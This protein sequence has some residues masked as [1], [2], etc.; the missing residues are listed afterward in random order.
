MAVRS[1]LLTTLA[2]LTLGCGVEPAGGEG[3]LFD[4]GPIPGKGDE[5][6]SSTS[7]HVTTWVPH[8]GISAAKRRLQANYGS[9]PPRE[10]ITRLALQ[11]YLPTRTGG[12]KLAGAASATDVAWFRRYCDDND[13]ELYLCIYN[14]NTKW[15]WPL[16]RSA[17]KDHRAALIGDL[18]AEAERRNFDGVDIDFEGEDYSA[19]PYAADRP[20]FARFIKE[21]A[22]ELHARGKKLTIDSTSSIYGVPNHNWWPDWA[23][24]ADAINVMGYDYTYKNGAGIANYAYQQ[25]RGLNDGFQAHQVVM[26]MPGWLSRWGG[27]SALD[28]ITDCLSGL[29]EPSG[30]AIWDAQLPAEAWRSAAVWDA[31]HEIKT[32]GR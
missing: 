28:N 1:L 4:E 32:V 9:H 13:I 26:G 5:P 16:A 14:S 25:R 27:H 10:T 17:F 8:Y 21:L 23:G 3:S 30:V 6:R 19:D 24:H 2:I 15:D 7:R 22:S 29:A 20:D 31:L 11:F 12:V 18:V